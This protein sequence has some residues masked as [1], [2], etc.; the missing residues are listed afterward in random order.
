MRLAIVHKFMHI[1]VNKVC[2]ICVDL[3]GRGVRLAAL[4]LMC[5]H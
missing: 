5:I 4:L 2:G 1:Y 3:V